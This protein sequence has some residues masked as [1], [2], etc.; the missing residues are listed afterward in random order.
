MMAGRS[1]GD[2]WGEILAPRPP[3]E[4][5]RT[6]QPSRG[7]SSDGGFSLTPD[8]ATRRALAQSMSR[9]HEVTLF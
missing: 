1:D 6:N 7:S 8:R 2:G 4:A 9:W 5:A 3:T